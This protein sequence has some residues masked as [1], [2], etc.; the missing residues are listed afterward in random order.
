MPDSMIFACPACGIK[1]TVPL[2]LVRV[3]G[4]CPSC[5]VRIQAPSSSDPSATGMTEPRLDPPQAALPE[6]AVSMAPSIPLQAPAPSPE[7]S[8]EHLS[9]SL[10]ESNHSAPTQIAA[11]QM[12]ELPDPS[13]MWNAHQ[14]TLPRHPHKRNPLIRFLITMLFLIASG[15]LVY[16]I[17]TM[18]KT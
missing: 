15:A 17:L 1:L 14:A 7:A 4:P 10:Q 9:E 13:E 12:P 18:I 11:R 16:Y 5:R 2:S 3:S 8:A 6:V